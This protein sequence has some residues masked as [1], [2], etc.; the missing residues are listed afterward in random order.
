MF[1]A[2]KIWYKRRFSDPEIVALVTILLFGFAIVYFFGSLLAPFLVAIVIAYLLEWPVSRLVSLGMKRWM[3]TSIVIL[4]FIG[5]M[6]MAFFGLVPTIWNQTMELIKD[7]PVMFNDL[8]YFVG[9]LPHRYPDLINPKLIE[10]VMTILRGKILGIG[11]S[12]L[13]ESFSSLLNIVSLGIYMILVPLLA[14][15]LLKDKDELLK[16]ITSLLPDNRR[17]A[18]NVGTEMNQKISN[19]IRGKFTEVLIVAIA[20]YIGLAAFGLRYSLLLSVGVGLSVLIPYVGAAVIT[21]PVAMVAIFQFGITPA[22][23][24]VILT[25]LVIQA[26]DANLLVPLIFSEAVNLHPVWIIVSVLFFGGI[27]GFWGVFFAIPLATLVKTVWLAF[28]S[29]KTTESEK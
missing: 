17:L 25:Y 21:I 28:T 18:N 9:D 14:F 1:K 6:L 19:Y 22:L 11:E 29:K 27:W 8:Q 24:W 26:L 4:F 16:S 7:I 23:G 2:L 20:T 5:A 3:S 12:I 13:K 15:F 10:N